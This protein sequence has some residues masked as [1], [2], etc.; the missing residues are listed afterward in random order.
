L[1]MGKDPRDA[2]VPSWRNI[3]WR[4]A[5]GRPMPLPYAVVG[6]IVIVAATLIPLFNG[7]SGAAIAGLLGLVLFSAAVLVSWRY[8][9]RK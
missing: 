4:E 2:T 3:T 9:L 6:F 5:L 1:G 7:N 8:A